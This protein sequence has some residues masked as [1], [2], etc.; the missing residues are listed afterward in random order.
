MGTAAN[1]EQNRCRTVLSCSTR[2]ETVTVENAVDRV[3][4][5]NERRRAREAVAVAHADSPRSSPAEALQG[6]REGSTARK[7]PVLLRCFRSGERKRRN[8]VAALP[9]PSAAVAHR[10]GPLSAPRAPRALA[11]PAQAPGGL[12]AG[13]RVVKALRSGRVKRGVVAR[14]AN[15]LVDAD[16]I[17]L[18]TE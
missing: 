17:L 11:P 14:T 13:D 10:P 6:G 5:E 8:S 18:Y 4:K 15:L 7:R 1:V 12:A 2:P 3:A 9:P 16:A